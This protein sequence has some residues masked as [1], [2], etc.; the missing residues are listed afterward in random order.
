MSDT[1]AKTAVL[2]DANSRKKF[3]KPCYSPPDQQHVADVVDIILLTFFSQY[4]V[5]LVII[6]Y[7]FEYY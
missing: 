3:S 4:E 1:Y 7:N 5:S 2:S 6:C